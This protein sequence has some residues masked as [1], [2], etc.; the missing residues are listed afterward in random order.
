MSLP[1]VLSLGRFIFQRLVEVVAKVE[2]EKVE[3]EKVEAEKVVVAK[4]V[5]ICSSPYHYLRSNLH[6]LSKALPEV[7]LHW[8]HGSYASRRLFFVLFSSVHL[9][10]WILW[11]LY[12]LL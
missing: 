6:C 11:K 1:P 9:F 4:Q 12:L 3:A 10:Y 7:L 8:R 2:V 5:L